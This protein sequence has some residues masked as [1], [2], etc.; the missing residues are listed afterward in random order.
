[1]ICLLSTILSRYV[2][3]LILLYRTMKKYLLIG[4]GLIALLVIIAIIKN[5]YL[6]SFGDTERID[7]GWSAY[8][9]KDY[10]NA[11]VQF[12][13]VDLNKNPDIIFPLADSYLEI[14]E[15]YNAIKYL[16]IAYKN[17]NYSSEQQS[18][19][20][21]LLGI[22]YT[23]DK[24]YN[25]ARIFLNESDKLGNQKSKKNLQILDSLE[26]TSNK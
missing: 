10:S 1:M 20:T 12:V 13:A 15:P 17:K 22:A 26:N 7:K 24:D 25:K 14:G 4:L 5:N 6:F 8:E 18:Q 2:Y 16:E 3:L 23:N 9:K 21:N 19:I 11:V